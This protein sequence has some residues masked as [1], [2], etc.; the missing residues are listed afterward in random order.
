MSSIT[1]YGGNGRFHCCMLPGTPAWLTHDASS[2]SSN[3]RQRRT[4]PKRRSVRLVVRRE[5]L[6]GAGIARAREIRAAR[7]PVTAGKLDL[8]SD[9]DE[10][11]GSVGDHLNRLIDVGRDDG[12]R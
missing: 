11:A 4:A 6:S 1:R 5:Q 9:A 7:P 8:G 3:E 10:P 12:V 2:T